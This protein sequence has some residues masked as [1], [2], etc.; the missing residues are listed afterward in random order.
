MEHKIGKAF[1]GRAAGQGCGRKTQTGQTEISNY[2]KKI[3]AANLLFATHLSLKP[4]GVD[5]AKNQAKHIV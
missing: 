3:C 4:I 5:R 1:W 2:L